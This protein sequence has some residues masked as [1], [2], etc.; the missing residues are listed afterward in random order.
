MEVISQLD[1][2]TVNLRGLGEL[3]SIVYESPLLVTPKAALA[4]P[5]HR[6][7]EEKSNGLRNMT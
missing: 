6:A 7:A 4:A 1:S 2:L 5:A 3:A